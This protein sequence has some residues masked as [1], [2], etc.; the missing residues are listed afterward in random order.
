M[1]GKAQ[2]VSFWRKALMRCAFIHIYKVAQ[3]LV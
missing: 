2:L 3:E 1:G